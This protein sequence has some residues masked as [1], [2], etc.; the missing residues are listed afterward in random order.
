MHDV[1][2]GA[3]GHGYMWTQ[4]HDVETGACGHGYMWT[5]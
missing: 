3:C 5:G 4:V 1:E 2:T